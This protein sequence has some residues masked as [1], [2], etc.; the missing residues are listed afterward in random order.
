MQTHPECRAIPEYP[1]HL[2]AAK[3]VIYVACLH[4]CVCMCHVGHCVRRAIA[5]A[6]TRTFT[7]WQGP[8]GTGKTRTLLALVEVRPAAD[9]G[10]GTAETW[11]ACQCN[12][13]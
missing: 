7:L 1:G 8:P 10:T 9:C 5:M 11:G 3:R 6:V 12:I 13:W 2:Q 4:T